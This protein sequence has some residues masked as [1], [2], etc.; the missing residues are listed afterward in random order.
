MIETITFMGAEVKYHTPNSKTKNRVHTI[1]TKEPLTIEWLK[2]FDHHTVMLD[3]GANVGMYTMLGAS[4]GAMVYSLEAERKNYELLV[5]NITL[6]QFTAQAH[7]VGA[8]DRVGTSEIHIHKLEVGSALHSVGESV[9]W[10]LQPKQSRETQQVNT[11]TVDQFCQ[12]QACTPTHIKIDVDGMEHLV[13]Q[14][15]EHTIRQ[16]HSVLIELNLRLPQHCDLV[17]QIE[18]WG[19]VLQDRSMRTK[20]TFRDC[21]E[22]LF[23]RTGAQS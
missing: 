2:T 6:N 3:V 5:N 7:H 13:I 9:D 23:T 8:L 14:G 20:G 12:D 15:A 22:H 17:P 4:R 16:A 21:G 11:I 19:Y 10:N 1:W 18:S